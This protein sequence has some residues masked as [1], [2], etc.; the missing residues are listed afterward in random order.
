VSRT[1]ADARVFQSYKRQS[2]TKITAHG[3][4]LDKRRL[5]R[6]IVFYLAIPV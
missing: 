6:F 5:N 2:L 4:R 1:A 3:G